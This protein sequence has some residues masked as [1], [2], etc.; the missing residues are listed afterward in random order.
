MPSTNTTAP[1]IT[2]DPV[3][4]NKNGFKPF[5]WG[6]SVSVQR[7]DGSAVGIEEALEAG[8]LDFNV[9]LFPSGAYVK[10]GSKPP[11]F[12]KDPEGFKTIRTDTFDILGSV[13][14]RY[15]V[16][17]NRE[18]LVFASDLIDTGEAAIEV[19]GSAHNGRKVWVVLRLVGTG[20]TVGGIDESVT[21]Y[22]TLMNDHAGQGSVT[23]YVSPV[24]PQ[25]SNL[26]NFGLKNASGVFRVRHTATMQDRL[27]VAS[28]RDALN[29]TVEYMAEFEKAMGQL[30]KKKVTAHQ[31]DNF[32]DQLVPVPEEKKDGKKHRGITVANEKQDAI[33]SIYYGSDNLA[34]VQ[35]TGYGVLQAVVEMYQHQTQGRHTNGGGERAIAEQRTT[36]LLQG[37]GLGQEAWGLLTTT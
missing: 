22:L 20:M 33:R 28:G 26:L 1:A 23:V 12:V 34:N 36:R 24:R 15:R 8:G 31:L 3:Q 7:T 25:C 9:G 6:S 21:P 18:A 2:T 32:L 29:L 16:L 5:Y 30:L 13:G 14:K 19:V 10:S 4:E 35:G 27:T 11:R 17:Q 37:I